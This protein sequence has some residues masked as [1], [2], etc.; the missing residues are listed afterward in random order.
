MPFKHEI[1]EAQRDAV[2]WGLKRNLSPH[3]VA[4]ALKMPVDAVRLV[5]QDVKYMHELADYM[6]GVYE[7]MREVRDNGNANR[8]IVLGSDFVPRPRQD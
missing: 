3:Q 1:T 8:T 2:I 6:Q 7:E 5:Q 4:H